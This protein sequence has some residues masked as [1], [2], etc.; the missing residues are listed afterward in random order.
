MINR[1]LSGD[2]KSLSIWSSFENKSKHAGASAASETTQ[3]LAFI[4]SIIAALNPSPL[5]AA[6]FRMARI[7]ISPNI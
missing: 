5:P 7:N 4:F 1:N 3:P 6:W 2:D